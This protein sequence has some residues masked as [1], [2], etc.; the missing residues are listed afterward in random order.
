MRWREELGSNW[1]AEDVGGVWEKNEVLSPPESP[2]QSQ[3]EDA[4]SLFCFLSGFLSAH[5]PHTPLAASTL[6]CLVLLFLLLYVA[7]SFSTC[8]SC[9]YPISILP[10]LRS[11]SQ[12][13]GSWGPAWGDVEPAADLFPPL[14]PRLCPAS[15]CTTCAHSHLLALQV[16]LPAPT[17]LIPRVSRMSPG[18]TP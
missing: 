15:A 3:G 1:R 11:K 5:S 17:T 18:M 14:L 6:K 8:S 13:S 12:S 2:P 16:P 9:H 10:R 7:S 4:E